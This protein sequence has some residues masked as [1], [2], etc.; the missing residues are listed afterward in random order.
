MKRFF[1]LFLPLLFLLFFASCGKKGSLLPPLPRLIQKIPVIEL[2]QKGEG[3]ILEWENPGAYT[4]GTPLSGVS[5]VEIW[6]LEREADAGDPKKPGQSRLSQE[7]FE[8]K[9]RLVASIEKERFPEHRASRADFQERLF[10]AYRLKKE[11]IGLELTFGLRVREKRRKSE[12][13]LV[14]VKPLALSLPP[15]EV[16]AAVHEDRIVL[17]WKEAA[18]NIDGTSPARYL[19]FNVYR[20]EDEALPQ[21]LNSRLIKERK[22][23]DRSFVGGKVY[24]YFVRASANESAPFFESVD[25]ELAEVRWKDIFPPAAPSGL[26]SIVSGDFI[27]LTWGENRELDL[28]GYRVWR[29]KEG[30]TEFVPLTPHPIRV[31]T[32]NDT[33]VEKN[34]RYHY[35]I[36]ALDTSGNESPKSKSVSETIKDESG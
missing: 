28:A 32:F 31:N 7:E 8:T 9:A 24:R 36:T 16:R 18:R 2:S 34:T 23:E 19:G 1:P 11:D 4:D 20:S 3:L 15:G 21:R 14:A 10:Y 5:E 22:Y 35:A 30:E 33:A 6:L 25:S 27:S 29:R 17:R 26:I 13:S 12:F